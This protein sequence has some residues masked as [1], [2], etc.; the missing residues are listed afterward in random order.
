MT[1]SKTVTAK[2]FPFKTEWDFSKLYKSDKDPKIEKDVALIE[3]KFKAFA[4]KYSNKKFLSSTKTILSALK[5]WERLQFDAFAKPVWY[6]NR[7]NDIDS[8]NQQRKAKANLLT[9]RITKASNEIIFFELSLSKLDLKLQKQILA[10]KN[11]AP[12][13]YY[14]KKLFESGKHLLTEAEEKILSLKNQI[15]YSMW[16]DAQKK[17]LNKQVINF[18]GKDLPIAEAMALKHQLGYKDRHELH[19]IIMPTLKSISHM[20]EAELV[21]VYTD[22]KI[23]D[24]LRGYNTAYQATVEEYESDLVTVENL[25]KVVNENMKISHRYFKARTK[26]LG[27]EKIGSADMYAPVTKGLSKKLDLQEILDKTVESFNKIKPEYAEFVKN[28]AINGQID[29]LPRE[30]KR[31]GGYCT[32]GN[33]C[34]TCIMLNTTGCIDD[35]CTL[36]HEMGHAIH[37]ESAKTQPALYNEFTISVAEVASTFFEQLVIDDL[38]DNAEDDD[39]KLRLLD[40]KM[41][42]DIGLIFRQISFFNYELALHTKIR[43]DGGASKE[44]MAEMFVN[45]TKRYVGPILVPTADDGYGFIAI[46]HLRYFFYVYSYSLGQIISRALVAK[47]YKDKTFIEKVEEF[48]KAG[49]S[50]SPRD[51]FLKT[52]ID[53]ADP[54][55][56]Q[57]GLDAVEEDVKKY[58]GIVDKIK[59]TEKK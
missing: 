53:I 51:I 23:N 15:T 59:K 27:L 35:I 11:F 20:A 57:A 12:Y 49:Q 38:I 1:K 5:D 13:K 30:G 39:K 29:F 6:L 42:G 25:V 56:I 16:V 8:S 17:L 33:N 44:E 28:F 9:S 58:E 7:L 45:E 50:L 36:A 54:K 31:G 43:K 52:G 34:P 18:Q 26:L 19:N 47:Y 37:F 21:A 32:S 41:R 40:E 2:E 55:F 48:L 4:K 14:L 10:D 24:E 46:P 22:K 3:E